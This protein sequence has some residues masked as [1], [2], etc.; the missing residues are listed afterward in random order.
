MPRAAIVV[1]IFTSPKDLVG[2]WI[3]GVVLDLL[4]KHRVDQPVI[5]EQS[6][7]ELIVQT[8]AVRHPAIA[9]IKSRVPTV[10]TS[11]DDIE[12]NDDRYDSVR[13]ESLIDNY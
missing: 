7:I 3:I 1:D 6:S 8:I 4:R 10:S 13:L 5:A 9:P 11:T 12:E 2:E